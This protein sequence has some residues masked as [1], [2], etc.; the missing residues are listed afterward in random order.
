MHVLFKMPIILIK[1]LKNTS[2]VFFSEK[3]YIVAIF[4]VF[5]LFFDENNEISRKSSKNNF[6]GEKKLFS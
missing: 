6:S 3:K 4:S 2:F 1:T 5:S